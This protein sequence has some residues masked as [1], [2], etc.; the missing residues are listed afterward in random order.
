[1]FESDDR[2][3]IEMNTMLVVCLAF[4]TIRFLNALQQPRLDVLVRALH[5]DAVPYGKLP[6][7]GQHEQ[8]GDDFHSQVLET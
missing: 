6:C 5:L 7:P 3:D 4:Q 1:M 8:L 2:Q